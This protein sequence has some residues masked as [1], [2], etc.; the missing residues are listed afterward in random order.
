MRISDWS[1]DVCSSDLKVG[2]SWPLEPEGIRQF[3]HGL[4]DVIVVEEKRAFI[5]SQIKEQMYNW[6]SATRPSVVGKY[7][8]AGEWIL[9]ST[10]EL[11][12]ATIARVIAKRL[13]RFHESKTIRQQL[14]FMELGRASGRERVC[15]YVKITVG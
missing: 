2:M 15:Q 5:E 9:P 12:P 11:T 14:A 4:E 13:A 3:A 10:N 7:D 6:D 8:E 1:S